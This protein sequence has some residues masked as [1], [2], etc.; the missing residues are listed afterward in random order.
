MAVKQSQINKKQNDVLAAFVAALHE[1]Q[2]SIGELALRY[3][4][5]IDAGCDM[6]RFE[7]S[8]G[9]GFGMRLLKVA[10]GKLLPRPMTI[11]AQA[12]TNVIHALCTLPMPEQQR[13][14]DGG[15]PVR[16]K[17]KTHLVPLCDVTRA[18][19]K[20]AID[21]V[22]GRGRILTPDEQTERTAKPAPKKDM[23]VSSDTMRLE[24]FE[25]EQ[26]R[27]KADKAGRSF[28]LFLKSHLYETGVLAP[29]DKRNGS[30]AHIRLI[31]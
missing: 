2:R 25:I 12:N 31:S 24:P 26:I 16:R 5:C 27:K 22:G 30:G 8:E 11:L 29:R 4:A 28:G 23:L 9:H 6:S 15:L 21:V 1:T 10:E 7:A 14:L 17:G 13:L 18:Q 3:K 19:V 20:Q